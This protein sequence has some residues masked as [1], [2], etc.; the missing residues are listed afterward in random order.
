VRG[1]NFLWYWSLFSSRSV[2]CTSSAGWRL[3][4][5]LFAPSAVVYHRLFLW[6]WLLLSSG[7]VACTSS[8]GWRLRTALFAPS[9]VVHHSLLLCC[10]MGRVLYG[11]LVW[12]I[13]I[14]F[15]DREIFYYVG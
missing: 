2:A 12:C 11:S 1:G 13:Y 7:S 15:F 10:G 9:A 4:T 3:R 5:A 14:S 6:S 8:A